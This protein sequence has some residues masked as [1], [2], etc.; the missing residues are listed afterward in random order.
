MPRMEPA[1]GRLSTK[2]V[3][4]RRF[5][6]SDEMMRATTSVLPPGAHGTSRRTDFSGHATAPMQGAVMHA[7]ERARIAM[8]CRVRF[9]INLSGASALGRKQSCGHWLSRCLLRLDTG[10]A[11]D[12][13]PAL[14]FALDERVELLRGAADDVGSLRFRDGG[15]HRGHLQHLVE[16]A[17]DARNERRVHARRADDA[18]PDAHV[19]AGYRACD[20]EH[21]RQL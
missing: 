6:S 11:D 8:Q 16:D 4:L 19:E 9:M 7:R 21:V 14:Q 1:P 12:F 13:R 3:C 15:A 5:V 18:V 2:T 20:R 17:V 10:G